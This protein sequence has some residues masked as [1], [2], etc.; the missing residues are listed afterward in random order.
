M[1]DKEAVTPKSWLNFGVVDILDITFT[2]YVSVDQN[3]WAAEYVFS[4]KHQPPNAPRRKHMSYLLLRFYKKQ[5]LV[6]PWKGWIFSLFFMSH[7]LPEVFVVHYDC[8]NSIC[9]RLGLTISVEVR[10][11]Y[12]VSFGT[13]CGCCKP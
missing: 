11:I 13:K 12:G 1:K 8:F 7:I 9:K 3:I 6:T 5:F 2:F 4:W 10:Y